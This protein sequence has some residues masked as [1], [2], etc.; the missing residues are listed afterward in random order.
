[1]SKIKNSC[2]AFALGSRCPAWRLVAVF[3]CPPPP[4]KTP[5]LQTTEAGGDLLEVKISLW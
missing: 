5:Y 3:R 2:K 4:K 1:M